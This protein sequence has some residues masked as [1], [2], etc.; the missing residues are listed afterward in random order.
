METLASLKRGHGDR[1]CGS[2]L[3]GTVS[4]HVMMMRL[5]EDF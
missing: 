2:Q 4:D 1:W 3:Y 5:A